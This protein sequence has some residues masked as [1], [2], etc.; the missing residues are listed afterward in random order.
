MKLKM[1][2]LSDDFVFKFSDDLRLQESHSTQ[3]NGNF[4]TKL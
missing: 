4:K 1:M 2:I 3:Q